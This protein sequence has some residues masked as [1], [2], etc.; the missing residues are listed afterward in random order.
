MNKRKNIKRFLKILL[1]NSKGIMLIYFIIMLSISVLGLFQPQLIKRIL[2]DAIQGSNIKLLIKLAILYGLISLITAMLNIILQYMYSKMQKKISINLKMNILKH[3]SKLSGN[4]FTNIKTGNILSTIEN[5][6]YTIESFGVDVL[7]SLIIDIFTAVM[8]LF[9]LIKMESSLLILVV[10]LQFILMF[11]QFKFN[12]IISERISEIRNKAGNISNIIEEYISNIMNVVITKSIFKFFK[13]YINKEKNIIKKFVKLD[14]IISCNSSWGRLLSSL[15]TILIYG[16]G[17][18][19]IINKEMTFG[20]LI[21]FQQ[22]VG[23][24]IGPCMEIINAN[25]KIQ[26]SSVSINRVFNITD[27]PIT[28]KQDNKGKRCTEDF[29]GNISFNEVSFSYNKDNKIL[30]KINL[31]FENGKATALVGSSGCGKTTIIKLLYRLWDA[32]EGNITI[33]GIPLKEYNLKS[34]RKEISIV[35]QDLLLFDDTIMNNLTLEKN[36]DK[37]YVED[38]CRKAGIYNFISN[39]PQGFDTIVGERGVKLSGGQKQRIAIVRAILNN[40]KIIIFDEAT[41]ALDS[42]SQKKISENM[43]EFL[44]E[45]TVIEIA[46]RLSSIKDADII[47]VIH[48]G[49]AVEKGNFEELVE[50]KGYYYRFLKEQSMD[51]DADS[52]A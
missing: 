45:K 41:S 24:F 29:K 15:I 18:Y 21:A 49:K 27:E 23:M 39:L 42:I 50:K 25:T 14:V 37:S 8:A 28:I 38:L 11:S 4:Y 44:K 47:Y 1:K 32:D 52:I 40:S 2:D 12:K 36:K 26:R 31:K 5:D 35:T 30:D 9:F 43:K 6:I 17:G 20:E 22:Y 48:K 51:S 10:L 33:D 16:Y 13:N 46:H 3:I 19:K 34:I 7:F